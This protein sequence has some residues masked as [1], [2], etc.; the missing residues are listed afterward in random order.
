MKL[1]LFVR[2]NLL[3]DSD[4]SPNL[5]SPTNPPTRTGSSQPPERP[6]MAG[7]LLTEGSIIPGESEEDGALRREYVLVGDTRAVEFNRAVDGKYSSCLL[8]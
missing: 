5:S 1:D 4:C 6:P 2:E 3:N 8:R 7:P